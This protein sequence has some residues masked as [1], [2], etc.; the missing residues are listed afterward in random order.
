ME[1]LFIRHGQGE[2]T[3]NPPESLHIT[4]PG[5]TEAGILQAK[6]L[7]KQ[8][9]LSDTELV[10]SS[11]L[12]RTLQTTQIW[13]EGTDCA[14]MVSP[15]V[16]PRMFPQNPEWQTLP[17]DSLLPREKVKEEFNEFSI[18]DP[19]GEWWSKGINKSSQQAFT[20]IAERFLNRCKQTGKKRIYIVS[21]DGTI[22]AYRQY[23]TGRK[24]S[25]SDFPKETGEVRMTIN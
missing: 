15:L 5:L 21:H 3:L 1:L 23:M 17:C 8:F 10:I 22:T 20:R 12:R 18:E 11:P 24:L 2:H 14:K 6:S 19:S 4:D 25:R 7:R 13:S 16:S 9:P